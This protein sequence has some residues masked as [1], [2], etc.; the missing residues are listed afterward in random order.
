[1]AK[2]LLCNYE[3]ILENRAEMEADNKL[4][5]TMDELICEMHEDSDF[6]ELGKDYNPIRMAT[7]QSCMEDKSNVDYIH[8]EFDIP[9]PS[10]TRYLEKIVDK[11][12]H[13]DVLGMMEI[14]TL[15]ENFKGTMSYL[16]ELDPAVSAVYEANGFDIDGC[17]WVIG[18]PEKR[19][20]ITNVISSGIV[21]TFEY[22]TVYNC[23]VCGM[24][25][26]MDENTPKIYS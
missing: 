1:M 4:F 17:G 2:S 25:I 22:M 15:A 13:G 20:E 8:K 7:C 24:E 26:G 18:K 14:D 23:G 6:I 9:L 3:S 10:M 19:K 11:R 16:C 5:K 12:M 21:P